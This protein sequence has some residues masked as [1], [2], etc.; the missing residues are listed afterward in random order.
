VAVL[1]VGSDLRGDD[2]AGLL[3]AAALERWQRKGGGATDGR[4][5]KIFL[6]HTAPENLTGEIKRFNPTHLVIVGAA[7][8]GGP[9][10]QVRLIDP[11]QTEGPTFGTHKMP[12][13]V[14]VEYLRQTVQCDIVIV[15]M[16]HKGLEFGAAPSAEMRRAIRRV[17][18]ALR[19]ALANPA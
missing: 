10:G 15:A 11:W 13:N 5:W 1:A 2:V 8:I 19:G 3:V 7:D 4:T 12:P 18:G 14:L 17:T 9:P 6:G 16:Q